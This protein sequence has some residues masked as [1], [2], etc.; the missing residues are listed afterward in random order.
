MIR[1]HVGDQAPPGLRPTVSGHRRA[2]LEPAVT[3]SARC[4]LASGRRPS[5]AKTWTNGSAAGGRP[6]PLSSFGHTFGGRQL[7]SDTFGPRIDPEELLAD[8]FLWFCRAGHAR[9]PA[10]P[11]EV[12]P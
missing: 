2:V 3:E 9:P 7:T 8:S 5:I 10:A 12:A 6:E 11:D 1:V 4:G